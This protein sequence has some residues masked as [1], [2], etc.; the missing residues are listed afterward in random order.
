MKYTPAIIIIPTFS[1]CFC[2]ASKTRIPLERRAADLA[3]LSV[4]VCV[5]VCVRMF[6]GNRGGLLQVWRLSLQT[7]AAIVMLSSGN[8]GN[9]APPAETKHCCRLHSFCT[10]HTQNAQSYCFF[11]CPITRGWLAG[12]TTHLCHCCPAV[13]QRSDR[14]LYERGLPLCGLKNPGS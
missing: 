6:A 1:L 11:H 12:R 8:P 5:C 10:T 14:W 4:C 13:L 2:L 7:S 3:C 9:V